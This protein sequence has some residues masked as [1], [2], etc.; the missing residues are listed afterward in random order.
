MLL[1]WT[2]V[3]GVCPNHEVVMFH[4][5]TVTLPHLGS[6]VNCYVSYSNLINLLYPSPPSARFPSGGVPTPT[7]VQYT[8]YFCRASTQDHFPTWLSPVSVPASQDPSLPAQSSDSSTSLYPPTPPRLL[9]FQRR[10]L[11]VSEISF[12]LALSCFLAAV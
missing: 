9:Y 3:R 2:P 4:P 8:V 1:A 10:S 12:N 5:R 11:A 7:P 6:V